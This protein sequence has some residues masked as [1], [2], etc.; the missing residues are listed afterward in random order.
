MYDTKMTL[1]M[2][3]CNVLQ[4]MFGCIER[5]LAIDLLYGKRRPLTLL[6]K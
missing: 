3:D 1:L 6:V 4:S 5:M 2:M